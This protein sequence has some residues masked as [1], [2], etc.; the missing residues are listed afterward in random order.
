MQNHV[1]G[2]IMVAAAALM[3]AGITVINTGNAQTGL[4]MVGIGAAMM[5]IYG[6]M[7][8]DKDEEIEIIG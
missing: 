2:G 5:S 8:R 1:K 6:F 3:T 4:I 7:H